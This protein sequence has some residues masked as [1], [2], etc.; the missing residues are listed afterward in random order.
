MAASQDSYVKIKGTSPDAK[1]KFEMKKI[2]K[3]ATEASKKASTKSNEKGKTA[4]GVNANQVSIAKMIWNNII[5]CS[6]KA[7][8]FLDVGLS[9]VIAFTITSMLWVQMNPTLFV[10][11]LLA[12][13]Q[14][15]LLGFMFALAFISAKAVQDQFSMGEGFIKD[16][17][18][19]PHMTATLDH[20]QLPYPENI[21]EPYRLFNMMI[22]YKVL[23]WANPIFTQLCHTIGLLLILQAAI[24]MFPVV[25]KVLLSWVGKRA[26]TQAKDADKNTIDSK[27]NTEPTEKS[28]HPRGEHWANRPDLVG[29]A[30]DDMALHFGRGFVNFDEYAARTENDL[31]EVNGKAFW[32]SDM[33]N[34]DM[35][36]GI[37]YL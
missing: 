5:F 22:K 8:H 14:M 11:S 29:G 2:R 9:K 15:F 25:K 19:V 23:S 16:L 3:S 32:P 33:D 7:Y 24:W 37:E 27:K 4:I 12:K 18:E 28:S 17:C 36:G 34:S 13:F 21:R 35:S 20:W 10:R 6:L 1:A 30:Y 26:Q 31:I